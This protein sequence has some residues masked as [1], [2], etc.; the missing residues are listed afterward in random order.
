MFKLIIKVRA[1]RTIFL[2]LIFSTINIKIKKKIKEF[3]KINL[4]K[5]KALNIDKNSPKNFEI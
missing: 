2:L 1:T 3:R 5:L 4:P